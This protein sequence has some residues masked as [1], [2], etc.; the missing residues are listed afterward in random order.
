MS[1]KS[2]IL[3]L[4]FCLALPA[5]AAP[6]SPPSPHVLILYDGSDQDKNPGRQDALYLTNLL[7]HF[8]TRRTAVPMEVYQPGDYKRYDA[9]FC[10]VYQRHYSVPS[11]V[12]ADAAENPGPFCWIGNQVNQLEARGALSRHGIAFERF[13]DKVKINQVFYK[14]KVLAKGDPETNF[15]RVTNPDRA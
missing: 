2:R 15:L 7:G 3:A 5:F 12:L 6:N 4:I 9:V 10:V 13:S 1:Q 8:T 11:A 14:G